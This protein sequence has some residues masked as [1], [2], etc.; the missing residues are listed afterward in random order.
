MIVNRCGV[1]ESRGCEH[2][3]CYSRVT[4]TLGQALLVYVC[5]STLY[6]PGIESHTLGGIGEQICINF[7]AALNSIDRSGLN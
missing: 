6:L 7:K 4:G 3:A 2:M 1:W 5:I